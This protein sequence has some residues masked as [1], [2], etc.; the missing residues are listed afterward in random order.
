MY[1]GDEPHKQSS[2]SRNNRI[3]LKEFLIPPSLTNIIEHHQMLH[4]NALLIKIVTEYQN[5]GKIDECMKYQDILTRNLLYLSGISD[6]Q[7]DEEFK[8]FSPNEDNARTQ[9]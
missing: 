1:H 7:A 4:E 2:S 3:F 6:F 9:D 5:K 8:P